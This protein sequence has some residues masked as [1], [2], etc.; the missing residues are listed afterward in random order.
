MEP[1]IFDLIDGD[2][3]VFEQEP[4]NALIKD[5]QLMSRL[6]R[7]YWQCMDTLREKQKLEELWNSGNAPWKVWDK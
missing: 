2:N 3:T 6:H 4:V 7:G 5:G 1:Q